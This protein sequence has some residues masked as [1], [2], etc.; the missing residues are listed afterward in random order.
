M[1][2]IRSRHRISIQQWLQCA[3]D[4]RKFGNLNMMHHFDAID[5]TRSFFSFHRVR[6]CNAMR[7]AKIRIEQT[8]AEN[9]VERKKELFT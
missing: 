8:T 9:R 6:Y 7:Q 4:A 3:F 5:F 1:I 2:C